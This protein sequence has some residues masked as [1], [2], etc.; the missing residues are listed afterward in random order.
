MFTVNRKRFFYRCVYL[1]I[2]LIIYLEIES[3]FG[4]PIFFV[5]LSAY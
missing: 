1:I 3:T 5:V 2:L 4:D